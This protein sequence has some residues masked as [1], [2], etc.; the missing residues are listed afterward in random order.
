MTTNPILE[1]IYAARRQLL[2]D[3]SGD[4]HAYVQEARERALKSGRPIAK[5]K[6][7]PARVA[8]VASGRVKS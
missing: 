3:H 1:E 2:A 5:P 7:R 4:I 6:Q 8:K